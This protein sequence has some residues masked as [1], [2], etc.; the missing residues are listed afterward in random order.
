MEE[1]V[2]T[3]RTSESPIAAYRRQLLELHPH[4]KVAHHLP[5]RLRVQA[6]SSQ[7][8]A[9]VLK[10]NAEVCMDA[11]HRLFPGVKSVRL[12]PLAGSL[13]VEY[14]LK[15]MPYALVDAFFRTTSFEQ[16]GELLDRLLFMHPLTNGESA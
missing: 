16:A 6:H 11:L 13:V 5:G 1:I 8:A 3:G 14:D 10:R 15:L 12:N 2:S 4:V 7:A 9:R